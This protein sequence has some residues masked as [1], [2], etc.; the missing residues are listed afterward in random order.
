MSTRITTTFLTLILGS[1]GYGQRAYG[2][3]RP[4]PGVTVDWNRVENRIA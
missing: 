4:G 1:L 3:R 2:Q